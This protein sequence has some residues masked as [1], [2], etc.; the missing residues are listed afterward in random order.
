MLPGASRVVPEEASLGRT[1]GPCPPQNGPNPSV[2]GA[3][4]FLPLYPLPYT[5]LLSSFR[6]AQGRIQ[7]SSH[8]PL[9]RTARMLRGCLPGSGDES[10]PVAGH[11]MLRAAH[12]PLHAPGQHQ[13]CRLEGSGK[14]PAPAATKGETWGAETPLRVGEFLAVTCYF[15]HSS[16]PPEKTE[17]G[18]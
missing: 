1:L 13:N 5:P 4:R 16:T 8:C 2:C 10:Q 14:G 11:R 6:K 18:C 17:V 15:Q 7:A 12:R 3:S 9:P